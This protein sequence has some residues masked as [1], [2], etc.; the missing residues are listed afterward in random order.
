MKHLRSF[1]DLVR[2]ARGRLREGHTI[3]SKD[4]PRYRLVGF[5]DLTTGEEFGVGLS[6]ITDLSLWRDAPWEAIGLTFTSVNALREA[7]APGRNV[8][9]SILDISEDTLKMLELWR[10][11]DE[12]RRQR[13]ERV[14]ELIRQDMKRQGDIILEILKE[15]DRPLSLQELFDAYR[16]HDESVRAAT[17]LNGVIW[18]LVD[19]GRADFNSDWKLHYRSGT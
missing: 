18:E 7:G 6:Y 9:F 19:L 5:E 4:N 12:A 16:E 14:R 13:E 1:Y 8:L 2:F 17:L 11:V 3:R 15:K 10:E